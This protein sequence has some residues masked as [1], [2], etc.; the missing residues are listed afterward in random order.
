MSLFLSCAI[1]A[2]VASLGQEAPSAPKREHFQ[3]ADVLYGWVQDSA[4]DQLRTFTTRPRNTGGKVPV[5]FFVG[6]LSCD[7]VEYP[8]A[9]TRDGFGTL[10]RR[11]IEE[12][13]YA[14]VR[15]DKPG[16]GESHGDCSKTDVA[17]ELSGY[18]AAFDA[19]LKL[20]FIDPA[21]IFVVGLSNGGG[22]SALVPRQR[23][24]SALVPR[25]HPVRGYVAASSWGRT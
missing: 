9:A 2:S 20:D 15:M 14:T 12:S 24:T 1:S 16:V 10:L 23:G 21:K 18:Q 22:T 6:W 8:D 19:M 3:S 5:I 13:A 4:G 25:Q 11:L 17:T 7:S